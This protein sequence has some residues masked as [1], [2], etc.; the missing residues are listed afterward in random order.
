MK[1][2]AIIS[3]MLVTLLITAAELCSLTQTEQASEEQTLWIVTELSNSDGMNYQAQVILERMREDYPGLT[4]NLEVLPTEE[5]ERSI[6]L[7]QLRTAIM[8]GN[9][10]D[11][12]LLPTG[13][14]LI[15]DEPFIDENIPIEP[16]F[17]DVVQAMY[18]GIFLDI[19][20]RYEN[21]DDMNIEALNQTVMNAGCLDGCRYVL[22]LRYNVPVMYTRT[23]LCEEYGFS[24]TLLNSDFLT[25]ANTVLSCKNAETAAIGLDFPKELEILGYSLDY[26]NGK[27]FLDQETIVEY[28][29]LCQTRSMITSESLQ[30]FFD[31]W[32]YNAR[33][34][35]VSEGTY[36]D[37]VWE[38]SYADTV[39]WPNRE[40]FC[41][42]NFN[43]LSEYTHN[44]YHWS[45]C[46]IPIY[47]GYLSDILETVSVSKIA[48][49]P[50]S[51]YPLRN[52]EGQIQAY[53]S[54]WG[55][56]GI[57]CKN[58]GLAY[59]FLSRFFENEYQWDIYRPRGNKEG[60]YWEWDKDPQP[61]RMVEDSLPVKIY[62]SIPYL[63]D[64]LQYQVKLS[65]NTTNAK[66]RRRAAAAKLL[67]IT[68]EDVPGLDWDIEAVFFPITL[69]S[70]ESLSSLMSQLN[71]EDG[72]PTD[73]DLQEM[74]ANLE[75]S[76]WWHLAEG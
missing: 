68:E 72:T 61:K 23:D 75:Q 1:R 8:S 63:W 15:S 74:A 45:T 71:T 25:I 12:Y 36:S 14:E 16:L 37:E 31:K 5:Q 66:S 4:I 43:L 53:V 38:E 21:D 67:E 60:E 49:V 29:S 30:Y 10:P 69:D 11:V 22:P 13:D 64:N 47:T 51:V 2:K 7:K 26:K 33:Q 41:L 17:S 52:A 65:Y 62:G 28:L 19:S 57:N 56:V 58:P 42:E 32:E 40:D 73:M 39:S 18:T 9:G 35:R 27:P 70:E 48:D 3:I 55:A 76:L 24:D 44:E 50:I 59:D 20:E 6:R 34:Y 54:Y 46:D